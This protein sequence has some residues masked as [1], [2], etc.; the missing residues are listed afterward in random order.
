[1]TNLIKTKKPYYYGF[2][3]KCNKKGEGEDCLS[4]EAAINEVYRARSFEVPVI[5]FE[6]DSKG[7]LHAHG[8]ITTIKPLQYTSIRKK[9]WHFY[10]KR[11]YQDSGWMRYIEKDIDEHRAFQEYLFVDSDEA[12]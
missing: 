6:N 7:K 2:T 11:V 1:M 9:G 10:H 12:P 8:V 5:R 4:I 3:I